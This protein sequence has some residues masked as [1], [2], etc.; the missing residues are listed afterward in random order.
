MHTM[1]SNNEYNSFSKFWNF[2]RCV[3]KHAQYPCN[4]FCSVTRSSP[5]C[6]ESMKSFRELR[7]NR[8]RFLESLQ[9]NFGE[10]N[11]DK[12]DRVRVKL[13]KTFSKILEKELNIEKRSKELWRVSSWLSSR[14]GAHHRECTLEA[15]AGKAKICSFVC[16]TVLI[17]YE[18]HHQ[19]KD[20]TIAELELAVGL[21]RPW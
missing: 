8:N 15:W 19:L 2:F 13:T 7:K 12:Q 21:K 6:E 17:D 16:L 4:A 3:V 9:N 1:R 5:E 10:L 20:W 18:T 11:T 14:F